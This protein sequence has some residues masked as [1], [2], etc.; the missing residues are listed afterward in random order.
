MRDWKRLAEIS[1]A[2]LSLTVGNLDLLFWALPRSWR[3]GYR[4]P[5]L[6]KEQVR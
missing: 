5:W 4:S 6:A 2:L 1:L 3:G